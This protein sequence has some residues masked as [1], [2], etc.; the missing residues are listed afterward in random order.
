M[1][2][3]RERQ[4]EPADECAHREREADL[5]RDHRRTHHGEERDHRED[6]ARAHARDAVEQRGQ[7][8]AG[9]AREQRER[10]QRAQH[11]DRQLPTALARGKDRHREQ[12]RHDAQVLEQQ[13]PDRELAVRRVDLAA[14]RQERDHERRAR[15]RDERAEHRRG[16]RLRTERGRDRS[17]RAERDRDLE[18]ARDHRGPPH[19]PQPVER[20]LEADLEQ[21]EYDAELG[22]RLDARGIV[23][24]A[25]ST[26]P[27]ERPHHE[28]SRDRGQAKALEHGA[29]DGGHREDQQQLFEEVRIQNR[30]RRG[31]PS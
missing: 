31:S 13:D 5:L 15:H 16:A 10:R 1:R 23:D 6:L 12:K 25:Q 7:H 22:E 27:E 9:D 17:D 18:T 30:T 11:R 19:P 3:G 21:Q 26:G 29:A 20:Q 24:P 8:E 14:L 28:E 4:H 2:V